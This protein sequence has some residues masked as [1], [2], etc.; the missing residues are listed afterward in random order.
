MPFASGTSACATCVTPLT[1]AE[2]YDGAIYACASCSPTPY[3]H[4]ACLGA[5]GRVTDCPGCSGQL[6]Q[7]YLNAWGADDPPQRRAAPD[8]GDWTDRL[9]EFLAEPPEASEWIY[10]GYRHGGHELSWTGSTAAFGSGT[11]DVRFHVHFTGKCYDGNP[12]WRY[13]GGWV[14]GAKR[15]ELSVDNARHLHGTLLP[16]VQQHWVA[17]LDTE[18]AIRESKPSAGSWR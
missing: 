10:E 13:G 7:E 14:S 4:L 9:E 5:D 3:Y 12:D 6:V 18:R 8:P 15:A 11:V 17:M 2:V 1:D 16:V